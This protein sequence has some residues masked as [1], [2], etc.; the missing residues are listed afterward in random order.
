M[1]TVINVRSQKYRDLRPNENVVYIGRETSIINGKSDGSPLANT[2]SVKKY[3]RD[4]CIRLY[5]KWLNTAIGIRNTEVCDELN[6]L[7]TIAKKGDLYLVCW[8]APLP[9]HG[10]IIK[11]VIES[12][13]E[14]SSWY[15]M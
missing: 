14:V 5:D 9:C 7:Y 15:Y 3:G 2:F 12:K 13:M 11:R 1:I 8:C 6:R 4:E 10:D